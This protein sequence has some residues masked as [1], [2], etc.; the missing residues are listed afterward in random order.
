VPLDRRHPAEARALRVDD[1]GGGPRRAAHGRHELRLGH[2]S[3]AS[4]RV[5]KFRGGALEGLWVGPTRLAQTWIVVQA[6][7]TPHGTCHI[8]GVRESLGFP[9]SDAFGTVRASGY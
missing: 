1:L 9:L 2:R 4:W 8:G 5:A 6:T 3:S 7:T